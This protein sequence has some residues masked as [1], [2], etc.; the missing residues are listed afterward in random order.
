M[1][2]KVTLI[3][4]LSKE[5]EGIT[6]GVKFSVAYNSTQ[7]LEDGG[8]ETLFIDCACFGKNAENARQYLK[9]GDL[10]YIEGNLSQSE[11]VD[12]YGNARKSYSILVSIF[13]SLQ[14][15][16]QGQK[17]QGQYEQVNASAY[18]KQGYAKKPQ[19]QK[20]QPQQVN[21]GND[22]YFDDIDDN[23]MPF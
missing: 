12:K 21:Q 20:P 13:R 23:S 14:P 1:F 18:K 5:V 7:K 6:N 9:K 2:C 4:R 8:Y 17:V 15:K 3:G 10:V 16:P 22:D 11:W 19:G